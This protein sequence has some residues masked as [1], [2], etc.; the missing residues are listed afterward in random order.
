MFEEID[1][2]V[3]K[4][5]DGQ[6]VKLQV[7]FGGGPHISVTTGFRCVDFRKWFLPTVRQERPET[8]EE[9]SRAAV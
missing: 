7:H 6:E 3:K 9:E 2:C 8:D 1:D 4:L 5:L